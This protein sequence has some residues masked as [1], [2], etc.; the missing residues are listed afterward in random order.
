MTDH[1]SLA[2]WLVVAWLLVA[3]HGAIITAVRLH[4]A[5]LDRKWLHEH[6]LNGPKSISADAGI[7]A[8]QARLI[9]FVALLAVGVNAIV[10][11][12]AP[13]EK[14]RQLI[15][16]LLFVLTLVAQA[17]AAQMDDRD[18]KR[19]MTM[20]QVERAKAEATQDGTPTP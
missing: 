8:A 13:G 6:D 12:T 11:T 5:Y 16:S 15:A 19:L 4:D 9:L 7:R 10:G 3:G 18:S 17:W 14:L 2:F 20:L 1:S